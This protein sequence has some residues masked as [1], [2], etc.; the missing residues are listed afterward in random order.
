M[1]ENVNFVTDEKKKRFY[2]YIDCP[3]LL[4]LL[5]ENQTQSSEQSKQAAESNTKQLVLQLSL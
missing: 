5:D 3:L 1:T 4:V 2:L